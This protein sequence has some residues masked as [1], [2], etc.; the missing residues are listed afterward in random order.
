M[1]PADYPLAVYS[2]Y[3]AD[4][5]N[6]GQKITLLL[7]IYLYECYYGEGSSSPCPHPINNISWHQLMG[8][9]LSRVVQALKESIQS[10]EGTER[11]YPG[12]GYNALTFTVLFH[13][14]S[15]TAL[16][17]NLATAWRE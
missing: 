8:S 16:S 3:S 12:E 1:N 15:R 2:Y 4:K 5:L 9:L 7:L 17:V 6:G 13:P 14:P 11:C 10:R